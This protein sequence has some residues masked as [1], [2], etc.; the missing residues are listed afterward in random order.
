MID[1]PVYRYKAR[2][3][4]AIDGD[5]FVALVDVGFATEKGQPG[6]QVPLRIRIRGVNTPERSQPGY[7]E[8]KSFLAGYAAVPLM[9]QTYKDERSFER[10]IADV[11]ASDG[12]AWASLAD[13]IIERGYGV[14]A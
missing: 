13:Q 3:L 5:T 6:I 11:W 9:V 1:G 14:A 7:L 4:R 12:V 10:W 8:A 2:L